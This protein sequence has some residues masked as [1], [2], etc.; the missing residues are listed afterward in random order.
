[1]RAP[2]LALIGAGRMGGA[3]LEAWAHRYPAL[4]ADEILVVDPS[5]NARGAAEGL[6]CLSAARISKEGLAELDS[7]VLALKPQALADAVEELAPALPQNVLII[8]IVAGVEI[9]Q[10]KTMFPKARIVRAM[11]NMPAAIGAGIT[12]FVADEA[13]SEGQRERVRALLEAGGVVEE[14]TDEN[15]LDAVTAISGSGPAYV[16]LLAEALASAAVNQGL[17]KALARRFAQATVA[18]AGQVLADEDADPA[19]LRELV[20]SPG[21]TTEAALGV[22][23]ASDGLFDL[24]DRAVDA[25]AWRA[26]ELAK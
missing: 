1:M 17:P 25:A 13:V 2:R 19:A 20:T 7:V 15:L 6:G 12:A 23:R 26:K 18:G 16:F 3:L 9:A 22:L 11:P 21:G 4:G 14:L 5:D 8:S 24:M 10:L